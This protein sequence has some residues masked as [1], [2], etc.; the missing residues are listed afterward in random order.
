MGQLFHRRGSDETVRPEEMPFQWVR[1]TAERAEKSSARILINQSAQPHP[2]ILYVSVLTE[3]G[4][5]GRMPIMD[6]GD[7]AAGEISPQ[8][9]SALARGA[10]AEQAPARSGAMMQQSCG[11]GLQSWPQQFIRLVGGHRRPAPMQ[12]AAVKN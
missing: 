2:R 11:Q 8:R 12:S 1:K 3:A 5:K 4:T 7:I 9:D 6:Y 10:L